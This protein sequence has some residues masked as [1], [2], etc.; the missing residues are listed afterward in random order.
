MNHII[1]IIGTNSKRPVAASILRLESVPRTLRLQ[2]EDEIHLSRVVVLHKELMLV[3]CSALAWTRFYKTK[4]D[5]QDEGRE[6]CD[7][8]WVQNKI[9]TNMNKINKRKNN[10]KSLGTWRTIW[11]TSTRT[12]IFTGLREVAFHSTRLTSSWQGV[13]EKTVGV[14]VVWYRIWSA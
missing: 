13:S 1:I 3:P 11:S 5:Q 14:P 10:A 12:S 4:W 8:V 6:M 9:R 2:E 7:S